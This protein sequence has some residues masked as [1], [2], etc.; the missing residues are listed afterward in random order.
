MQFKT[1]YNA[2]KPTAGHTFTEE[3]MALQSEFPQTT[4]DYYLKRYSATGVLGDPVRQ[5]AAQFGDATGVEDFQDAMEKVTTVRNAFMELPAEERRR[6][7]DDPAAWNASLLEQAAQAALE[8]QETQQ[9]QQ[10]EPAEKPVES[11]EKAE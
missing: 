11:A 7:G 2:R 9:A 3:S 5:Q 6:F 10:V 8:Q 1:R 4:I